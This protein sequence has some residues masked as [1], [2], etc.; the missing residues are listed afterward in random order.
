MRALVPMPS[1]TP[2]LELSRALYAD[3]VQPLLAERFPHLRYSAAR[4]GP[5]SEVLGF[6][7]PRSADH[8]WGPRLQ[9][10]LQPGDLNRYGDDLRAVLA[11]G[12]PKEI[13]GWP[14]HFES[15]GA[16]IGRMRQ[17]NGPVNH[18][19]D[20]T[21]VEAWCESRLGFD[22]REGVPTFDWL[23]T[24]SQTFA[25]AIGG[26]VF[27]DGLEAL[28]L[29]REQL[30]WYP[31]HVW[32]FMLASQWQRISE[33][34]AFA[35]RCQE[36]GDEVGSRVVTA[37]LARDLM[38]LVLL[39]QRQYPPYGKWLGSAFS[40]SALGE[41]ITPPLRDALGSPSWADREAVL[42]HVYEQIAQAHNDL[43]LTEPIEESTRFYYERPFLVIGADRFAA[44][45]TDGLRG[46]DLEDLPLIG[47]IDQFVDNTAVLTDPRKARS[48][49]AAALRI[50]R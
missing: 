11:N 35:G 40:A 42:G 39:M 9:L 37:R 25:E 29:M 22:P 18:R 16:G 50:P 44:A 24:P 34:E 43:G 14:T 8:E 7:T 36:V 32:H 17:A 26:A 20:V 3:A 15:V 45:L 33:E 12:L 4:I 19:V 23:A 38:R 1:F 21:S 6:D 13:L 30:C 10:F 48:V 49:A 27:H 47:N 46:T 28:T 2:G 41:R 5:G 31:P